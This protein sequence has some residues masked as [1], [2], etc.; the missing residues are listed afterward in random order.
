MS[1]ILSLSPLRLWSLEESSCFFARST[2]SRAGRS[3]TGH[4]WSPLRFPKCGAV[5]A[6]RWPQ[7]LHSPHL[8]TSC[9]SCTRRPT[10]A[11][12]LSLRDALHS[13]T[14]SSPSI[15]Y[16]T[17]TISLLWNNKLIHV[18]HVKNMSTV[19]LQ[20]FLSI[21]ENRNKSQYRLSSPN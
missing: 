20:E 10:W 21:L 5:W 2:Q 18:V 12:Q 17:S 14:I 15:Y 4:G 9:L 13:C 6:N 1:S 16:A 11:S 3:R 7:L 8:Q 19:Y